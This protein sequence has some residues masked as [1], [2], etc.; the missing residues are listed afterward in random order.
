MLRKR[1]AELQHSRNNIYAI[2]K[3]ESAVLMFC[4]TMLWEHSQLVNYNDKIL[5]QRCR[6]IYISYV[7]PGNLTRLDDNDLEPKVECY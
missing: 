6:N 3:N 4:H 2:F 5:Q 1:S 7:H